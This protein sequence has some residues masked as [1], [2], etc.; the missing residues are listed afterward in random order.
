MHMLVQESQNLLQQLLLMEIVQFQS[1]IHLVDESMLVDESWQ[2]LHDR[3]HELAVVGEANMD[4]VAL[5]NLMLGI[6]AHVKSSIN[7]VDLDYSGG[8]GDFI[9]SM[10]DG[11][12]NP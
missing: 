7:T 5:H 6:H 4:V 8:M 12:S 9:V 11:L 1:S 2:I 3:V 10:R